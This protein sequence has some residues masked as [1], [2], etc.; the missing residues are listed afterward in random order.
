MPEQNKVGQDN[1]V[2]IPANIREQLGIEPGDMVEWKMKRESATIKC[3]DEGHSV[4]NKKDIRVSRKDLLKILA[5]SI[6]TIGTIAAGPVSD[7]MEV[8][9]TLDPHLPEMSTKSVYSRL[10]WFADDISI[11]PGHGSS[12]LANLGEIDLRAQAELTSAILNSTEDVEPKMVTEPDIDETGHIGTTAGP[13]GSEFVALS[14]GYNPD[15][16]GDYQG[17]LPYIFDL[18]PSEDYH[19]MSLAEVRKNQT[20]WPI[21]K[22]YADEPPVEPVER[23]DGSTLGNSN[24]PK[25]RIDYGMVVA[26]RVNEGW[27]RYDEYEDYSSLTEYQDNMHFIVAGCHGEGTLAATKALGDE[28]LLRQ[29]EQEIPSEK[30]RY[31]A[32]FSAHIDQYKKEKDR[33]GDT[34][35][36]PDFQQISVYDA[37][38]LPEAEQIY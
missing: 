38:P 20:N 10:L 2:V 31:Q 33:N 16:V 3:K 11:T 9:E 5:G 37:I 25:Y 8:S 21:V 22:S 1:S 32:V 24:R 26:K 27:E 18:S 23:S 35:Y 12:K 29:L 34:I 28:G 30:G 4:V 17:R 13:L 7:A 15:S 6:G 19:G 36:I 14:M